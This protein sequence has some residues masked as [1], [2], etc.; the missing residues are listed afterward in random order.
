MARRVRYTAEH[1]I[2]DARAEIFSG[3]PHA[4]SFYARVGTSV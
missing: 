1:G 2:V 3:F 4:R